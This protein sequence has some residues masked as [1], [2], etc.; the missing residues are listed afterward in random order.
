MKF[1]AI[2]QFGLIAFII[3]AFFVACATPSAGPLVNFIK[4]R[5]Q[6]DLQG[7]YSVIQ[8]AHKKYPNDPRIKAEYEQ[9]KKDLIASYN[10]K[11]KTIDQYDLPAR[12]STLQQIQKL[13]TQ[14]VVAL[15]Q[16]SKE[17]DSVNERADQK[18]DETSSA[19]FIK[20]YLSLTK[21][22]PYLDSVKQ[23]KDRL[24]R[25]IPKITDEISGLVARGEEDQAIL[26]SYAASTIFPN[27]TNFNQ[28]MVE[29]LNKKVTVMVSLA[30]K[31]SGLKTKDRPATS[32]I[33]LL[34]GY[35]YSQTPSELLPLIQGGIDDLLASNN[36]YVAVVFSNKFSDKQKGDLLNNLEINDVG[37]P[38]LNFARV[39]SATDFKRVRAIC[40]LNLED[41]SIEEHPESSTPY[42]KYQSGYQN[43]P[44]PTYDSLTI[45]Y[46]KALF[47]LKAANDRLKELT[48]Q[49]PYSSGGWAAVSA[50]NL[51]CALVQ[52]AADKVANRLSNTP[53][54]LRQPIYADYQYQRADSKYHLSASIA[55]RLIDPITHES[56]KADTFR[57]IRDEQTFAISG[58]HPQDSNGIKDV[59]RNRNEAQD[60]LRKFSVTCFGDLSKQLNDILLE[61]LPSEE[62]QR[63]FNERNYGEVAERIFTYK[64]FESLSKLGDKSEQSIS[65]MASAFGIPKISSVL[66]TSLNEPGYFTTDL[67]LGTV[68]RDSFVND[69]F[70]GQ[71][72]NLKGTFANL[73]PL[74]IEYSPASTSRSAYRGI[75]YQ[76]EAIKEARAT[77][78]TN[79]RGRDNIIEECLSSVVVIET[80]NGAGSGFIIDNQGFII[81]NYHVIAGQENIAVS[82]SNGDKYQADI[83]SLVKFK[84]LALLKINL[85]KTPALRL[86][87]PDSI[88]IGD[89]VYALGAPVGLQQTVTKGI[90]SAIRLM[91]APYN[92]L[93]K[94]KFIQTDAAINPGNSGGPLINQNGEVIGVNN[95]KIVKEGV[96]GINFAISI[97]EVLK[98]FSE[99]I[100]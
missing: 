80:T 22:E 15:G 58:A 67:S 43:V 45:E 37:Q 46:N 84:D 53:R 11:L 27:S 78:S 86:G 38:K 30:K 50:Q 68:Y 77:I 66:E 10:E 87:N 26:I 85:S 92:S 90:V 35:N 72:A 82:M 4:L 79:T 73:N 40:E 96:E 21:Y 28:T 69:S 65:L 88:R 1:R 81:T 23:L 51:V 33:Y 24:T 47:D 36:K 95:Q 71:F 12:I 25:Y 98:T 34:I 100:K 6:G 16:T 91:P 97:E 64:L 18:S 19:S 99:Y 8:E 44:N 5:S 54:L 52:V 94:I 29:L 31:Y 41:L 13:D 61:L 48:A 59:P 32:L 42:S 74:K 20:K 60:I 83:V 55:Y 17:L 9:T 62:A 14:E 89:P 2:A 7:A 3:S 39:D 49:A 93:E 76:G 70:L 57:N 75:P 56:L 63:A